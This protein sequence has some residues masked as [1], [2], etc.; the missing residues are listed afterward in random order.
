M[1]MQCK[2]SCFICQRRLEASNL[3]QAAVA[4]KAGAAST[5]AL[6]AAIP[7]AISAAM[8]SNPS[9]GSSSSAPSAAPTSA[10]SATPTLALDSLPLTRDELAAELARQQQAK[11]A[12]ARRAHD[13]RVKREAAR[14]R[15]W[16]DTLKAARVLDLEDEAAAAAFA[17]KRKM[18]GMGAVVA[19]EVAD[20]GK[21]VAALLIPA[22]APGAQA[23]N[24]STEADSKDQ[25]AG[26][27]RHAKLVLPAGVRPIVWL[28]AD[29][30]VSARKEHVTT[31]EQKV[32]EARAKRRARVLRSW[33]LRGGSN[34]EAGAALKYEAPEVVRS[35]T[36]S[37]PHG[38][39]FVP[40]P[41][42][43]DFGG[44]HHKNSD[45]TTVAGGA[46]RDT[47]YTGK[48]RSKSGAPVLVRNA[49]NG[50]PAVYF[51]CPLVQETLSPVR[52]SRMQKVGQPLPP[53]L[54]LPSLLASTGHGSTLFIVVRPSAVD[55]AGTAGAGTAGAPS[56]GMRVLGM[57]DSSEGQYR[58][59]RGR[60]GVHVGSQEHTP[61]AGD[62]TNDQYATG[63]VLKPGEFSL[64]IIRCSSSGR[65]GQEKLL[66]E[67]SAHG[68]PLVK[69]DTGEEL[70]KAERKLGGGD[71][72]ILTSMLVVGGSTK[73]CVLET[74][75]GSSPFDGAIAEVPF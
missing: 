10:P 40:A 49:V 8:L 42:V 12:L 21:K 28:R 60:L 54:D 48:G 16:P 72:T 39:S 7:T 65:Q 74:E 63:A 67:S 5:A 35:W 36:D 52:R 18:G 15:K 56:A 59:E 58:I 43:E 44:S 46:G 6:P 41:V 57:T 50:M 32:F 23:G 29:R 17:A 64:V 47:T 66:V 31:A 75:D 45:L 30:G 38:F 9:A 53:N 13:A 61:G 3:T 25:K 71:G 11:E 62:A 51:P 2:K 55:G 73:Q 20:F 14:K 37:G 33:K 4:G 22:S 24:K 69:E 1:Q 27:G 34:R 19:G 70:A 26:S 68:W